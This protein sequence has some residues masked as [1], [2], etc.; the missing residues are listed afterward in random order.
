MSAPA[1][2]DWELARAIIAREA[3]TDASVDGVADGCVRAINQLYLH[4]ALYV[5]EN[6][7]SAVLGRAVYLAQ[8]K[9]EFLAG[10]EVGVL[11]RGET[12]PGLVASAS[13][14]DPSVVREGVVAILANFIDVLVRFIG[15]DLAER[16]VRDAMGMGPASE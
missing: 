11:R 9:Y 1:E 16:L 14:C 2:A 13:G 15:R 10:V 4:L 7:F 6:G 12:L 3:G 5:G 8:Q